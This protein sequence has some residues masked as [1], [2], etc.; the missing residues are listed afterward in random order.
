MILFFSVA[1]TILLSLSLSPSLCIFSNS[2]V[3]RRKVSLT[4][5]NLW[6]VEKKGSPVGDFIRRTDLSPNGTPLRSN[7]FINSA[8]GSAAAEISLECARGA[9]FG[10]T[11]M[12]P[13]QIAVLFQRSTAAATERSAV[14]SF[15]GIELGLRQ[16]ARTKFVKGVARSR[17]DGGGNGRPAVAAGRLN[18][19]I[20]PRQQGARSAF[21]PPPSSLS[22]S[23][24]LS[25]SVVHWRRAEPAKILVNP[26]RFSATMHALHE[27]A[28]LLLGHAE[29]RREIL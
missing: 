29:A 25:L 16:S 1:L 23:L 22:L 9:R 6:S 4:A 2:V 11:I 12:P 18:W 27:I 10:R 19:R 26:R 15:D 7:I 20:K 28:A 5:E 17:S 21:F 8:S 14:S 13:R 24:S 3:R